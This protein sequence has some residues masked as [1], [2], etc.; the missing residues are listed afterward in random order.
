VFVRI[1]IDLNRCLGC[2]Q[3]VPLAS[4][5]LKL[6]GEE[7]SPMTPT[8]MRASVSGCCVPRRRVRYPDAAAGDEAKLEA[9]YGQHPNQV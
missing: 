3:C 2:A 7:A 4:D 8:Q 6:G 1:V 9:K 5:V